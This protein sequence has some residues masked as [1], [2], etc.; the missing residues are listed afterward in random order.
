MFQ[1]THQPIVPPEPDCP[2]AGGFVT[3]A[4]RVRNLNEGRAVLCLEYEAYSEMADVEGAALI[5]ETRLKFGLD[6]V[7]VIHRVGRL[8]IGDTSVWIGCGAP[9][10]KEAFAACEFLIDELKH[11]LPIWKKEHFRDGS[12]EWLN[13]HQAT[14]RDKISPTDVFARQVMMPEIGP[15]G[16]AALQNARV[17]VVGAGGLANAALPYLAG[18]GLGVIGI[19]EP[20]FL[21]KS[22][23][24]RQVLFGYE[25]V[26][27]SKAQL[28]AAVLR[29]LH[30]FTRI[31]AM[32]ERLGPENATRLLSGFDIVVDGTDRFDAKFLLN[33]RCQELGLPLVQASIHR[34][35]G[36]VQ[37]ILP[38]GP[39]LRCQWESA[40]SDGC[41]ATCA[42]A[43]VLGVVPGLFGILQATEV[44]KLVTGMEESL[45]QCQLW[46]DLRDLAWLKV[47]RTRRPGCLCDGVQPTQ[48]KQTS[49]DWEVTPDEVRCWTEPFICLDLREV[50]E[51]RSQM[52]LGQHEW[53][54]APMSTIQVDSFL[55]N[56]QK[57]L[58]VCS[59]G[60][61]S[62]LK[63]YQ[64]RS[65]GI[66]H[67]Y[68]LKG[69]VG[70]HG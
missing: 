3:F 14:S 49:A 12:S 5:E 28:A 29:R 19:V 70:G 23:L 30:P 33:D 60:I 24:H 26:G 35:D 45:S 9:H 31:V 59:K 48:F 17:L 64:L 54:H 46:I 41:V 53:K 38:G 13:P 43:G 51:P 63:V 4:G 36:Y 68:S 47:S 50:G 34:M 69:G 25:D 1:I 20:G 67:V 42:E 65:Q 8:E 56:N 37:T 18:A 44:I 66:Q 58:L 55:N 11:R 10:R 32:E 15:A 39:C 40:P 6:W 16:Q 62:G 22:N 21:E 61:R 57:V 2:S 27:R 52:D 7:Q